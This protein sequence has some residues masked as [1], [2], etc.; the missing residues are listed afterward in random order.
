MVP[1]TVLRLAA[2]Q[3]SLED[4]IR[5]VLPETADFAKEQLGLIIKSIAL[6][7]QQIPHEYAVHV[8]DAH[9]FAEFG[10]ELIEQLPET[11]GTALTG[12]I[13]RVEAIA[14]TVVP[15]RLAL[16]DAVRALRGAI[17]KVLEGVSD[18]EDLAKVGPI[19]LAQTERQTLLERLWVVDTGFD[20]SPASLPTIEQAL[21]SSQAGGQQ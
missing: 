3:K 4:I 10:R 7:R 6:V 5:P 19:V 2:V 14:P 1:N 20:P 8:H 11:S 21:Y 18:P 13:E 9:A 12:A 17:E 16:E 15:D